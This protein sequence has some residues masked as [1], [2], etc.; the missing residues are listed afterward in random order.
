VCVVCVRIYSGGSIFLR[1]LGFQSFGPRN[2]GVKVSSSSSSGPTRVNGLEG[3][4]A[5]DFL[6]RDVHVQDSD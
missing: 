2:R 4:V 6:P 3:D 5:K 1:L